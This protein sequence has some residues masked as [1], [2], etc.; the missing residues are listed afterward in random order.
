MARL[1]NRLARLEARQAAARFDPA[2][3][4][5]LAGQCYESGE[6]LPANLTPQERALAEVYLD[7]L[8]STEDLF[9]PPARQR[10]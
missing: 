5:R 10:P 7:A 3:V 8:V 1:A 2:A 4:C 9:G 6:P